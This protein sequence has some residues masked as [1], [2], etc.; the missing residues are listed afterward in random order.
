MRQGKLNECKER[1]IR[2]LWKVGSSFAEAV[3]EAVFDSVPLVVPIFWKWS[4]EFD[5]LS[6]PE[7]NWIELKIAG[8]KIDYWLMKKKTDID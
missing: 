5:Q 3:N 6:I 4:I 8:K 1:L 7:K 2:A